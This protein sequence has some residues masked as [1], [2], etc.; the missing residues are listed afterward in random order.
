MKT[1]DSWLRE[2]AHIKAVS[3]DSDQDMMLPEGVWLSNGTCMAECRS[4]QK[5]YALG[6]SPKELIDMG[7]DQDMS[8]CG[9]T[10]WCLP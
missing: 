10:Q 8:Y 6:F 5:D 2:S 1:F 4:C 7:F 9:R 3:R